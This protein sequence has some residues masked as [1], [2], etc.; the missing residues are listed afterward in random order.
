MS[1]L[2]YEPEP[3]RRRHVDAGVAAFLI[4][5]LGLAL[6]VALLFWIHRGE[7][8][9]LPDEAPAPPAQSK[10]THDSL[11]PTYTHDGE[12]IRWYVFADPD[13]GVQYL[14]NDRG[15]CTP[16]LG[17]TGRVMGM[18][19]PVTEAEAEDAGA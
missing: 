14:V 17:N 6:S 5:L 9:E 18:V 8:E 10:I 1:S 4:C 2:R 3:K 16:R 19:E 11:A 13:T 7:E 12:V 15:G